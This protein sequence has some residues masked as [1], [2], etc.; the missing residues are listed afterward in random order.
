MNAPPGT[1]WYHSHVGAQRT[2][3]L[4][5]ALIIKDKK[6]PRQYSKVIDK[7]GKQTIVLQEWCKSPTCQVPVSILVNGKS[8]IPDQTFYCDD[9]ET[10]KYLQGHGHKVTN[11]F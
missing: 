5:G 1:Y 9:E 2:N 6:P 3:G 10:R 7:P 8:R 11:E 4:E